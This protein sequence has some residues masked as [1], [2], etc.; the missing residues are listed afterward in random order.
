MNKMASGLLTI[1]LSN[2][3]LMSGVNQ[4]DLTI[5][6][7]QDTQRFLFGLSNQSPW[8]TMSNSRVGIGNSNPATLLD[9]GGTLNTNSNVILTGSLLYNS[10]VINNM[11]A[12]PGFFYPVNF[13][14][15]T[16]ASGGIPITITSNIFGSG[17]AYVAVVSKCNAGLEQLS[18]NFP[19]YMQVVRGASS[20]IS[21]I[22]YTLTFTLPSVYASAFNWGTAAPAYSNI[23]I[24][25]W[26]K[27]SVTGNHWY[28]IGNSNVTFQSTQ[29]YYVPFNIPSANTW[30]FVSNTIP[31]P[32]TASKWGALSIAFHHLSIN[33][34]T[35]VPGVG[36]LNSNT[37]GTAMAVKTQ[38]PSSFTNLA[39][40]YSSPTNNFNIAAPMIVPY[41][42]TQ[43]QYPPN[44]L[45]TMLTEF[46]VQSPF[47]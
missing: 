46:S 15:T 39:S 10:N 44:F 37:W 43:A 35:N 31:Y 21:D 5:T 23:T 14:N 28:A 47:I 27:S 36:A 13:S 8:V 18:S 12:N 19:N 34:T 1:A 17:R 38:Y 9:V 6:V 40:F 24:S 45:D 25:F 32:P 11:M 20:G 7:N 26:T 30:T 29:A 42:D 4:S 16:V 33:T 22:H 41:S 2:N 3:Y